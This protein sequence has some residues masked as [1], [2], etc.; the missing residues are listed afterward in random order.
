MSELERALEVLRGGGVVAA[1]T[2]SS[3]GLLARAGSPAALDALHALKPREPTR[4]HVLILPQ[5]S[6]WE[7]LV[8]AV[9]PEAEALAAR[10]WPGPLTIA[11]PAHP[12][13]DPRLTVEGSVA[14]RWPGACLA[15]A[16]VAALGEPLTATSANP[17]GAPPALTRGEVLGYFPGLTVVG[18]VAPGGPPSTLVSWTGAGW[19]LVRAGAVA[20][21]A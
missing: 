20:L 6:A 13:V 9:P 17:S 7:A 10:A 4:G 2:E 8:R 12:R 1:P 11:L 5:R 3:Y 19:R 14:A 21:P 15:A 16:L 18:S